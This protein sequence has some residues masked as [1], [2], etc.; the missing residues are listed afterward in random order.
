MS[1]ASKAG[2]RFVAADDFSKLEVITS[3][4]MSPDEKM[5]AYTVETVADD[6]RK[7]FSHIHIHDI[8]AGRCRQ[9]TFGKINDKGLSWSPDS[10]H[11]A[12]V[13]TRDKKTGI[14]L[15]PSHGGSEQKLFEADGSFAGLN[16]T[17]DGKALVYAFRYNDSHTIEDA[18][19]KKEAPLFRHIT[20]VFYKL[21]GEGFLPQDRYHIYRFDLKNDTPVALTTGQ[22]DEV[23]PSVSPDGKQVVFVSN[24]SKDPDTM[25]LYEDLF[26]V[27]TGGGKEKKVPTPAGPKAN[28]VFSP[29]SKKLAYVAHT[30]PEDAWGVT[31]LHIWT[32]G[33]SGKPKA[34]DL[35]PKFDR[36]ASDETISDIGESFAAARP[37]WS[38]D[39]K[40]VYFSASD[41]GNTH[42]FYAP[43]RG[44]LPTRI[45]RKPCHVKAYSLNGKCRKIAAVIADLK[46]P[47]ELHILATAYDA[48]KKSKPVTGFNTKL[49][50]ELTAP[51]TKDVWIKSPDGTEIQGWLVTPPDFKKSKK[52]PAILEIHGGPVAQYGFSYFHEMQYLASRGYVVLYTNPRGGAG[53]GETWVETIVGDWGSLDYIDCMAAA[54]YLES[55]P[56]V[57][58]NRMGVTGGSYGG[59]MTNWIIGHTNRF[60]AAVT[61]RSVV[62]LR[63]MFGSSDIGPE[64]RREFD[65]TPWDNFPNYER[66]SPLTYVRQIKTPL[67]IIH[68]EQD[69]RCPM[70][71]AEQLFITMKL[72][73][74]RVEMVRF[75][76]EPHGL[77]RHGR[78]DRRVARLEWIAKWFNRYL[79]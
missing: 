30:N 29:D 76:E 43:A 54:D 2:K 72:M 10:S 27:P 71:Q 62:N 70:E 7:Y 65:G 35:I 23:M 73:K 67:L 39:G 32:V 11:L 60:K 33:V 45:T 46:Q 14:Y 52:Y 55:L 64:L 36:A 38:P 44:G 21:D 59:Y 47:S 17:P 57:D 74:K 1:P 50:S 37:Y 42:L 3:A 77:S 58:K 26:V 24:R 48:D 6:K 22:Y 79:K 5:V 68:S 15:I 19:K 78:P 75:P 28:P 4:V 41:L 69:L 49:F 8:A 13:S 40:R 34:R 31:N 12:F 63:S 18:E 61:Q 9:Y 20:R 16:W 53:R 66:C 51:V 25:Q 56:Y